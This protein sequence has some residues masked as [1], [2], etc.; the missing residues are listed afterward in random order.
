MKKEEKPKVEEPI[1]RPSILSFAGVQFET[2]DGFKLS[3]D[4]LKTPTSTGILVAHSGHQHFVFYRQLVNSKWEKL[5]P[6]QYL[7]Q[8]KEEYTM[9][10]KEVNEKINYLS[11]KHSIAKKS[12]VM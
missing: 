11:K 12:S 9:L 3:E 1:V 10:E 7:N 4:S 8:A 6:Y 5:I 2:S